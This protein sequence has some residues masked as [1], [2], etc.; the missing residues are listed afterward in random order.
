MEEEDDQPTTPLSSVVEQDNKEI[1]V[2]Q[3]P[4]NYV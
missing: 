3:I 2:L 4:T 1:D